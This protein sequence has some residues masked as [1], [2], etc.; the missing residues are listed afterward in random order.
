MHHSAGIFFSI[1]IVSSP[2]EWEFL[3]AY[4]LPLSLGESEWLYIHLVDNATDNVH[5]I[6]VVMSHLLP[7]VW[8][9][10]NQL[11]PWVSLQ[12]AP[13]THRH[14]VLRLK[15]KITKIHW[16]VFVTQGSQA[17]GSGGSLRINRMLL[18]YET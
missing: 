15:G 11:L 12:V 7:A 18:I 5:G 1:V 13:T 16:D 14:R 3:H 6:V 9:Q 17:N 4:P 10:V 2:I 8:G